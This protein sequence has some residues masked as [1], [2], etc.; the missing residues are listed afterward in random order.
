MLTPYTPP[1]YQADQS[2]AQQQTG[3]P[4]QQVN[5]QQL[6]QQA[7]M[8]PE[9]FQQ[10]V[11]QMGQFG[12]GQPQAPVPQQFQ[13]MGYNPGMGGG[14]GYGQ[15]QGQLSGGVQGLPSFGGGMKQR[16]APQPTVPIDY[17][18]GF[19]TGPNPRPSANFGFSANPGQ[20]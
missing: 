4:G 18:P 10:L 13:G 17:G 14:M 19:R 12:F 6:L 1:T 9:Q 2:L 5:L 16:Y 3:L 7:G 20:Y 15:Q 8:T 11:A